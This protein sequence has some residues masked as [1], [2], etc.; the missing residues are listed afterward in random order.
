MLASFLDLFE[1]DKAICVVTQLAPGSS[2]ATQLK[3]GAW[4]DPRHVWHIARQIL[5][6]LSLAHS[7]GVFHGAIT[8]TNV[9]IDDGE[10]VT[11]TD[12]GLADLVPSARNPE[13]TAPEQLDGRPIDARTD[14][15][16]V[17]ALVYLLMTGLTPFSGTRDEVAKLVRE[18]R[19]ADPSALKPK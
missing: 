14:L 11:L 16:Q 9:L 6:A 5:D 3:Q 13:F 2:L 15:Y 17:G 8:P 18:Q 12:M 10:N 4:P 7:R 1:T 19:P